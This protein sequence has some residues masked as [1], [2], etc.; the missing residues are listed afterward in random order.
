LNLNLEPKF[1]QERDLKDLNAPDEISILPRG[2]GTIPT[3][4]LNETTGFGD[5]LMVR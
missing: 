1:K 4:P 5:G 3:G 2:S